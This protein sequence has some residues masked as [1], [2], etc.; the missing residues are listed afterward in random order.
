M[1]TDDLLGGICVNCGVSR[2]G[3]RYIMRVEYRGATFECI[4]DMEDQKFKIRDEFR[5]IVLQT[6]FD[7]AVT[8]QNVRKKFPLLIVFS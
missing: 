1:R 5:N 3:R 4:W 6:S 7:V 2:I 8:P